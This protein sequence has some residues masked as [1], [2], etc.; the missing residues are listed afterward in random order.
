MNENIKELIENLPNSG[1]DC[2]GKEWIRYKPTAHNFIDRTGEVYGRLTAL[3]PVK[4]K[5][6]DRTKWLCLCECKNLIVVDRT[7]LVKNATRSCGCLNKDNLQ[8]RHDKEREEM[9]GKRFGKLTVLSFEGV[10]NGSATF[11]CRCDCG[12]EIIVKGDS[13]RS[14]NTTSCGCSRK[15]AI[16]KKY[17]DIWSSF[18]G[19]KINYL[20]A[21]EFVGTENGRA[22]FK[23]L[24][25]CGNTIVSSADKIKSG[26]TKS[27]G[28]QM[29]ETMHKKYEDTWNSFIGTKINFLTATKFIGTKN[30]RAM[31]E[32]ECECG[33]KI[34]TSAKA[35]KSG[36]TKSCGCIGSSYGEAFISKLLDDSKISYKKQQAFEDL[37]AEDTNH[38]LHYDF[39]ILNENNEVVRLVEFDGRQHFQSVSHFGGE[40]EFAR[41]QYL[42]NLKNQYAISHN[43]PLVRIPY[44][45]R[46][47]MTL[48][49]LLSD[50]YTI[51]K[52]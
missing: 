16:H 42:D 36:N 31:F 20:T 39:A 50:K 26:N 3:F 41:R 40:E 23:F 7:N 4:D 2:K 24:C 21:I 35:V 49:D 30:G 38:L 52:Q 5:K 44:S 34:I 1:V 14:G 6:A 43:I 48:D 15:E 12:K 51:T 8:H 28:C 17:E 37:R 11:K 27:C 10:R 9:I 18:I 33:N 25:D 45:K 46:D 19:T 22:I 13:L 29:K 32:F 47:S